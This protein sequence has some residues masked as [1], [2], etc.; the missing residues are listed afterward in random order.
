MLDLIVAIALPVIAYT[1]FVSSVIIIN[2][3]YTK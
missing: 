3:L 1:V 2:H